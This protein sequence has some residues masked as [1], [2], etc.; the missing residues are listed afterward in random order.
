[1]AEG[2]MEQDKSLV[3]NGDKRLLGGGR[4]GGVGEGAYEGGEGVLEVVKMLLGRIGGGVLL[5]LVGRREDD[6]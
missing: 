2:V 3:D 6:G 1:M 5:R 4:S